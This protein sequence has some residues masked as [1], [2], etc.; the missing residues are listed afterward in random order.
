MLAQV[1]EVEVQ[2]VWRRMTATQVSCAPIMFARQ[3]KL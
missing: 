3:N 1:V 2:T